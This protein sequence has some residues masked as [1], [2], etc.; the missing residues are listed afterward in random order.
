MEN[1]Q[2]AVLV[3]VFCNNAEGSTD[4]SM[5]E[6]EILAQS[7]G[8]EVVGVC[9]QNRESVNNATYVGSGKLAEIKDLCQAESPDTVIFDDELSGSQVRN[10]EKILDVRVIDRSRLILDIFA[11]RAVSA[12]GKC[13]VELAQ[14]KYM[15]PRLS[16]IGTSMSRL[17]GGIGTRGP[18]ETKLETD[19]R[20]IKERIH[21]LQGE[22][23]QIEKHRALVRKKRERNDI[24]CVAIVGYTNAGKSTLLNCLTHAGAYE[25]DKLFATLDPLTRVLELD[26]NFNVLITD[27]VGFIR[28]LPHH[29]IEAFRSTLEES[30]FADLILHV[31]DVT[32]RE[33]DTHTTVVEKLLD[34][35]G[36]ADKPIITV[37][38]KIDGFAGELPVTPDSVCVSAKTGD[39]IG[40]LLDMM[41]TRLQPKQREITILIPYDKSGELA[42]VYSKCKPLASEHTPDGTKL[43][44]IAELDAIKKLS[45]FMI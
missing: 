21:R 39:G 19:R 5:D 14:L 2:K 31:A 30:V 34:E 38:N 24:A 45:E 7:A 22:L 44:V 17:G 10:I 20:H 25:A 28:K 27:T 18:G 36:A 32:S 26:E 1:E 41:K 33:L 11:Q 43:R 13:Q 8:T 9:V 23:K 6:L 4:E 3:G 15:L 35:L 42:Y 16:G 37:Y 29:L 12:E 40:N